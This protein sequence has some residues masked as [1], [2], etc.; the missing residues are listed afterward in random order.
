MSRLQELINALHRQG[1]TL[2][3]SGSGHYQVRNADGQAVGAL[4]CSPSD[5]RSLKN[6]VTA[7]RKGGFV[8]D[9]KHGSK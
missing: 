6:A 1:F 4:P 8:W 2:R 9:P 3:H 7:L 5:H